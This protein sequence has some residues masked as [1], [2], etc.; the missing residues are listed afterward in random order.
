MT[1]GDGTMSFGKT[2]EEQSEK[3]SFRQ[4]VSGLS[5]TL[6]AATTDTST[7]RSRL[8]AHQNHV[9]AEVT[10]TFNGAATD[11]LR[12]RLLEYFTTT[13]VT[14]SPTSG[15]EGTIAVSAGN[16]VKQ[17]FHFEVL[18]PYYQIELRNL[19]A[20]QSITSIAVNV[21]ES[22]INV[23]LTD[24]PSAYMHYFDGSA[25]KTQGQVATEA[26]L[27]E[28]SANLGDETDVAAAGTG[29][30]NVIQ[31]L[32]QSE[33]NLTAIKTAVEI[34]DDWDESDR[35]KVN[36]IAGQVGIA[37]NAGIMDALT[38]RVT[39]ATD[40]THF[41]MVGAAA[42]VDGILHAQQ[43]YIG[44]AIDTLETTANAI[45][46][47]VE[48]MDDWDEA[49]RAAVNLIA[50][51]VAV[52]GGAGAV[53]ANTPR[54]TLASDDPAVIALQT[55]DDWDATHDG[56]GTLSADGP[57]LIIEAVD[58][59]GAA[60][61]NTA[62]EGR[63]IRLKGL[64]SGVLPVFPVSED[65]SQ[66]PYDSINNANNVQE[67]TPALLTQQKLT[68]IT[69]LTAPG[70]T[71]EIL[72]NNYGVY[73]YTF[74]VAT[75][76]TNVIVQLEGSIDESNY[77]TLPI[78]NTVVTNVAIANNQMTITANGTYVIYSSAPMIDVRFDWVSEA[79]GAA[80]TIDPDFFGRRK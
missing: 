19:D 38:T 74:T 23:D 40:D 13:S 54:T 34:M 72:V 3:L 14:T 12:V 68:A 67:I 48:I 55:I 63:P 21:I 61:P 41:G 43:R 29:V 28:I 4:T 75:I 10:A 69:Q 37:A 47:A 64:L 9:V 62:T 18:A 60:F 59:D 45:Q 16:T 27:A 11:G 57:Q 77:A 20:A 66:S 8:F 70:D 79:G 5:A 71:A 53:A 78:D 49:N 7:E 2:P 80:A 31:L 46:T 76:D 15:N 26:T 58:F 24:G 73:G 39:I 52:T 6:T 36:P 25:W 22:P 44:E 42:D 33:I 35:A 32:K 1:E 17:T 65:G 51:Q 56:A 30:A 50:G